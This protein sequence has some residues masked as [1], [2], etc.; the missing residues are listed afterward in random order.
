VHVV[1]R[2]PGFHPS[3]GLRIAAVARAHGAG[4]LHCH[5]YTPFIYGVVAGLRSPSLRVVVT[6]HGRLSAAPPSPRRRLANRIFSRRPQAIAAVSHELRG[7]MEAEGYDP[8]R[9]RVIHN[10]VSTGEEPTPGRRLEARVALGLPADALVIGSVARFDPVKH[11]D[12]LVEAFAR[13]HASIPAAR[14]ALIGDGPERPGLDA[15]VRALGLAD[16][17]RFTGLRSDARALLAGFDVYVNSSRSEGISLTILEAMA[18]EVAVV[19]TRVGG[20]AEAIEHGKSGLLVPPDDARS[21]S[22]ALRAL[23]HEP[24]RR[25]DLAREGRARVVDH[26]S[27]DGMVAAYGALYEEALRRD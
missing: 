5:Q 26:F 10:G 3:L 8:R 27:L 18:E 25:A 24:A 12:L 7:F 16:V 21:L 22:E 2:T 4:L 17:I 13:T 15:Q 20:T 14:L 9:L 19:A 23:L 11:L 6:E 1:G